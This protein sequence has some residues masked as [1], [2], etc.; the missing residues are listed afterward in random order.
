MKESSRPRAAGK[1]GRREVTGLKSGKLPADLLARC[2]ATIPRDDPRVILW[3][4][5]GEDAA[6]IEFGER[7]LVAKTDPITFAADLI[8]WYAVNINANDVITCG[9]EPRWFMATVLL[10]EGAQES[11]AEDIFDQILRACADLGVALVGGHTEVTPQVARPVVVGCML[12][13]TDRRHLV[14]TA[15]ARVGDA[16]LLTKGVAV[17][18]TAL[19]AREAAAELRARGVGEETLRA[20]RELLFSPGISVVP[21]ARLLLEL[22]CVTAMHDPTE[23]GLATGLEELAAAS[24]QG[25]TVDEGEIFVLPQCSE[26]CAA[27]DLNPLGL[28]ASGALL[29][30]VTPDRVTDALERVTRAGVHA[31]AIGE[32]G[33]PEEGLTVRSPGGTRPLPRFPRDEVARYFASPEPAPKGGRRR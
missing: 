17:E 33:P 31:A 8:G 27:L 2:L 29:A 12:G 13:E 28:I 22:G 18:G 7:V 30:A 15:G 5:I 25:L 4:A 26:I 21:E 6:A 14:T 19:L 3:P 32:V 23:G 16:L 24:G 10:P 20:A 1:P 9:A 11:A